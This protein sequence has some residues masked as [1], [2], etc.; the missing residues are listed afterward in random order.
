MG[1]SSSRCNPMRTQMLRHSTKLNTTLETRM[2]TTT[3]TKRK[4]VPQ[5]GWWRGWMRQ[6]STVSGRPAS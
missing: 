6:F 2:D 4:L 3:T 5:R 1:M